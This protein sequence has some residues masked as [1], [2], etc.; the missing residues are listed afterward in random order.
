MDMYDNP[1]GD[2][3][4]GVGEGYG[5]CWGHGGGH[6]GIYGCGQHYGFVGS[7]W[8]WWRLHPLHHQH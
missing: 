1:A 2:L 6:G 7:G 8:G 3:T 4:C 5:C